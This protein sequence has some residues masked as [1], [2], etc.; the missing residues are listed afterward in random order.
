MVG[1]ISKIEKYPV[2]KCLRKGCSKEI[3]SRI[4]NRGQKFHNIK[5]WALAH[6]IT[7]REY[8][9]EITRGSKK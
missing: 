2:H 8:N 5:C 3:T 7:E 6:G 1:R 9:E 4:D